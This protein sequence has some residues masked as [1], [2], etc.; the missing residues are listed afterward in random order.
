MSER[1]LVRFLCAVLLLAV[2]GCELI[3]GPT[4]DEEDADA[5]TETTCLAPGAGLLS[6]WTGNNGAQTFDDVATL[7][8]GTL[9]PNPN[10]ITVMSVGLGVE[11]R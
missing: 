6:W 11:Y 1:Y 3:M 8:D 4:D 9:D 7:D 2:A 10:H 5:V